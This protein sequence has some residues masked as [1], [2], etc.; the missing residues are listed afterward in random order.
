[1]PVYAIV[2]TTTDR[3]ERLSQQLPQDVI[4]R[5]EQMK[6]RMPNQPTPPNVEEA[7]KFLASHYQYV[8]IDFEIMPYYTIHVNKNENNE[9]FISYKDTRP[10]PEPILE[11]V[12]PTEESAP[13]VE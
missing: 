10:P 13:L 1:M 8:P 9:Y 12:P 3:I 11:P 5:W 4:N 7:S 6:Q 2:N